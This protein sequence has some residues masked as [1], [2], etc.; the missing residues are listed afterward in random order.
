MFRVSNNIYSSANEFDLS[1][2]NIDPS[3]GSYIVS[4]P[5][6]G[7]YQASGSSFYLQ[8]SAS[9]SKRD[10]PPVPFRD[11][12]SYRDSVPCYLQDTVSG[13][14]SFPAPGSYLDHKS[15]SGGES[16]VTVQAALNDYYHGLV[17]GDM[18]YQEFQDST[19]DE[20]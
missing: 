15:S 12:V 6:K 8:G 16:A 10:Y 13:S 18:K 11:P 2:Y 5:E 20:K 9:A 1:S 4:A 19:A 14:L 3:T 7:I 17:T